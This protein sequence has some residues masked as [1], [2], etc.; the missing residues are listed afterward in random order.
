MAIHNWSRVDAGIFHDFHSAWVTSLRTTLNEGLL[1]EGFY[2]LGEQIAGDTG[3]DV[4]T[5]HVKPS[6]GAPIGYGF[7]HGDNRG[8]D[9]AA[10]SSYCHAQ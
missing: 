2:A 5:L 7:P 9:S 10:P 8:G 3:P 6:N 1:P 4:L